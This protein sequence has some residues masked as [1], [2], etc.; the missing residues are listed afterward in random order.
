MRTLDFRDSEI[1]A[2]MM[3]KDSMMMHF[4]KIGVTSKLRNIAMLH[5]FHPEDQ[6]ATEHP[7]IK[8]AVLS[9][10]RYTALLWQLLC[11]RA[12]YTMVYN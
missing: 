12:I 11:N 8:E 3:I 1:K 7:T 5:I 4:I 9:S 2:I 10:C 6:F